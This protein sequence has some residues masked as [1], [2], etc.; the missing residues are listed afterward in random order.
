MAN[1]YKPHIF[2]Y[3]EDDATRQFATGLA[4]VFDEYCN[5][6]E[7]KPYGHGEKSAVRKLINDSQLERFPERR[8]VLIIDLD[9]KDDRLESIREDAYFQQFA[10]RI[11]ILAS[12]FEV[13]DLRLIAN[14]GNLETIGKILG[15]DC[16]KWN[17]PLLKQCIDDACRLKAFIEREL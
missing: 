7:I 2:V 16:S 1:R 5:Q 12:F 6:I 10:D 8:A 11:F 15:G 17:D 9:K 3:T 4:S 14:T 13:E